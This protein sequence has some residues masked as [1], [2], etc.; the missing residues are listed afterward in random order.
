M[1]LTAVLA[2]FTIT[3]ALGQ[4]VTGIKDGL[5]LQCRTLQ[6]E[7]LA[8]SSRL[9]A[10]VGR[11]FG[12]EQLVHLAGEAF[13]VA[14]V[15][16]GSVASCLVGNGLAT[17][18]SVLQAY[19]AWRGLENTADTRP[20]A[21]KVIYPYPEERLSTSEAKDWLAGLGMGTPVEGCQW[22]WFL[23]PCLTEGRLL[24]VPRASAFTQFSWG[25]EFVP[26]NLTVGGN[27]CMNPTG[28]SVTDLLF[29]VEDMAGCLVPIRV[30][31]GTQAPILALTPFTTGWNEMQDSTPDV[32]VRSDSQPV[33]DLEMNSVVALHT[34]Q[35]AAAALCGPILR[36]ASLVSADWSPIYGQLAAVLQLTEYEKSSTLGR[37]RRGRHIPRF[38][39]VG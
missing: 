12:C 19:G 27:G 8:R 23:N 2:G 4:T 6:T 38:G 3:A 18:D 21:G 24:A 37:T 16:A 7:V 5:E 31:S 32:G 17:E 11:A 26:S 34:S 29:G 39:Q 10:A 33:S 30:G 14:M 25:A 36:V 1:A 13:G 35:L 22:V 15:I 9:N 28:I 20:C